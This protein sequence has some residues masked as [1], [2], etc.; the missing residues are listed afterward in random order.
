MKKVLI[1][2]VLLASVSTANAAEGKSELA[3]DF[4]YALQASMLCDN[5]KMRIDTEGKVKEI[6]GVEIRGPGAPH[7]QACL[8]GLNK[9]F[10]EEHGGLCSNVWRDF[11]CSG[12]KLS[13]LIQENPFKVKNAM[14]C[15]FKG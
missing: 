8:Q 15:E 11:G 9:A 3:E 6:I 12:E 2:G 4:C 5:L 1:I 14:L 7:N 13:G 10:E